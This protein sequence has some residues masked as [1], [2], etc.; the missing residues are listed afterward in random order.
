MYWFK[1]SFKLFFSATKKE[2]LSLFCGTL[3]LLVGFLLNAPEFKI[4]YAISILILLT[5]M[6]R[7]NFV[8]DF[9]IDSDL[10]NLKKNK[11]FFSYIISKNIFSFLLTFI[12]V[13]LVFTINLLITKT[14]FS[15]DYYLNLIYCG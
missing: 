15:Q 8:A 6:C 14:T 2:L 3:V 11:K 4:G 9:I 1:E 10:Q 13:F 7:Y 12:I 5:M